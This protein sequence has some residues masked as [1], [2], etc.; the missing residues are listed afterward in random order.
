MI[1]LVYFVTYMINLFFFLCYKTKYQ[2]TISPL[3]EEQ[4]ES[5]YPQESHSGSSLPMPLEMFPL[6]VEQPAQQLVPCL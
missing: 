2:V 6:H 3:P 4:H 5:C 1:K